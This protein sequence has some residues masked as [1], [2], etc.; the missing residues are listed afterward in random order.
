MMANLEQ[1]SGGVQ[2]CAREDHNRPE[3][4]RYAHTDQF[5]FLIKSVHLY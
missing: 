1:S 3:Q 4:K 2:K 5:I